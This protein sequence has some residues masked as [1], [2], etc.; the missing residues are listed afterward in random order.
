MNI[1][2]LTVEVRDSTLAKVGRLIGTDLVD[3]EFVMRF[4]Q[5]GSWK[6]TLH[7]QSPMAALLSQPGYGIIVTGANGVIMS[8]PM[9]AAKLVQSQED[10]EGTWSIEGVD[11]SVILSERLAYPDPTEADVSAQGAAFDERSGV[12]ETVL[13]QFVDENLVSGPTVRQVTGLTVASD[14]AR[15]TTVY[16]RARFDQMQEMFFGLAQTGGLGFQVKQVGTGLVFEVF[17]PVDRSAFVRLDIENGRLQ[18]VEYESKAPLLTRAIVAGAGELDERLFL[19]GTLTQSTTAETAWGRRIEK[20]V[21]ARSS[22]TTNDL[23]QKAEEALVDDGKTRVALTLTPTDDTTMLYARDWDLGDTISATVGTTIVD[24]VVYTVGISVKADGLYI[25]AE[26]GKPTPTTYESDLAVAARF[27]D[28]RLSEIERTTTGYGIVT[29]FAGIQV[30]SSGT[31]PTFTGPG[32]TATYTRF[33]DMVHFAY[34]V[35][36][37]NI[38]SFGTGQYYMTLPYN[39]RR[40]HTFNGGALFDDSTGNIY[41]IIGIVATGSNQMDF[42]YLKS[43][44]E[45]EPFEHN[46]P[47][48]LTVDDN[49]DITG[50]YEKED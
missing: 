31:D 4:N 41:S 49:F 19:E 42:Y 14:Q 26:V 39:A 44:G 37:D 15:G 7:A 43:N 35:D 13:K 16:G 30:G 6:V 36:F 33:G 45:V 24:A 27:A 48:T 46:K 10:P 50:I 3:S 2:D 21:D 9:T 1:D 47:I 25:A 17:E 11:D 40:P 12:A 5:V 38:S 22:K 23:T 34:S 18:Q 32:V 29:T 8:G 20:L 28:S